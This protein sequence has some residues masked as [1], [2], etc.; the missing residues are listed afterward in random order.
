MNNL[1]ILS[2]KWYINTLS[3][4]ITYF[5]INFHNRTNSQYYGHE[6]QEGA[7]IDDGVA[8]AHVAVVTQARDDV[9]DVD[10]QLVGCQLNSDAARHSGQILIF[11][12]FLINFKVF[13]F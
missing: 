1:L 4:H 10:S 9:I 11:Y 6:L 13:N 12:F 3:K 2:C 8:A 7:E 5:F